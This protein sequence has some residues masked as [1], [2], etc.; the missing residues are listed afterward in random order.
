MP[1]AFNIPEI[2]E[3]E[4]EGVI[5]A[6]YYSNKSEVVRDA[7]RNFFAERGELR[8]AA[9]VELYKKGE[10]TLSRGAEIAGLSFDEFKDVVVNRG[11]KIYSPGGSKEEL[12][13]GVQLLKSLRKK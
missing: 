3:L 10:V 6:G 7:L 8:L 13:K 12:E 9:A 2:F 4:I 1:S 5:D 11:V